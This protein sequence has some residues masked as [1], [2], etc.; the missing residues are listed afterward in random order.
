MQKYRAPYPFETIATAITF[1]P[2]M[3][4]LISESIQLAKKFNARLVFIHIGEKAEGKKEELTTIIEKLNE[5]VSFS[6][7]CRSG[8]PVDT[9]LEVCK[10]NIVDLLVIG[11]LEKETLLKY[12]FGSVARNICRKAKCSV[13]LLTEPSV[14]KR[15]FNSIVI[16][17]KDNPKTSFTIETASYF[18]KTYGIKQLQI[19]VEHQLSPALYSS[20]PVDI[21]E[22]DAQKL[23]EDLQDSDILEV[24][25]ILKKINTNGLKVN[26]DYVSG[27]P[28]FAINTYTREHNYDLL[29]VNSPDEKL[30]IL[31]RIFTNDFEYLLET[32]PSNLLIVHSRI[33]NN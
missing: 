7:T 8:E 4:A 23:K 12:F 14:N 3:D 9:I 22:D 19:V 33:N 17:A 16:N 21:N 11:A 31:D 2:R 20:L 32:L 18:A 27:K 26:V 13:L 10:E 25:N 29:V 15:V 24:K 5:G 30:N 28:G 6:V 1:S